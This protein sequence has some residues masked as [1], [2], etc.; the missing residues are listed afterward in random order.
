MGG[1]L[2]PG[3]VLFFPSPCRTH[4]MAHRLGQLEAAYRA[5][6]EELL[7]LLPPDDDLA[8]SVLRV[9]DALDG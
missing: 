3:E 5:Q 7:A 4:F 9:L 8:A 1:P 2:L 6:A